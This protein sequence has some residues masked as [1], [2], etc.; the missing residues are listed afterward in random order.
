MYPILLVRASRIVDNALWPK[1]FSVTPKPIEI[2]ENVLKNSFHNEAAAFIR[3][4][5]IMDG[6]EKA[7]LSALQL[8]DYVEINMLS[9]IIRTIYHSRQLDNPTEVE[10]NISS[11]IQKYISN[12]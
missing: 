7:L 9:D 11:S 5:D 2:F 6:R 10:R 1:L 8:L 3:V 4:I 12:E